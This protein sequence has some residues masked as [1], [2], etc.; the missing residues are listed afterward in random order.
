MTTWFL[1][2]YLGMGILSYLLGSYF[3]R[4]TGK[5]TLKDKICLTIASLALAPFVLVI[6]LICI[7]LC[8]DRNFP[9]LDKEQKW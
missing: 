7:F 9:E 1:L 2:L 8:E 4:S 3:F 5:Y 6:I